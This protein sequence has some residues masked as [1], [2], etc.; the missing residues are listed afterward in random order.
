[1]ARGNTLHGCRDAYALAEAI[2]KLCE[3]AHP[4]GD[5][6]RARCPHHDGKSDTSL[7]I[8]PSDDRVLLICRAQ[9]ET[10]DIV[11]ALHLTMADLFV[12]S[13]QRPS[14]R[15]VHIYDYV[16][17]HGTLI[18][19]TVRFEP[20]SFSQRRPDPVTPGEFIWNL[21]IIEPVLYHLPHVLQAV[22]TGT[23][24]YL[25]EG[26][27]DADMLHAQGL[28]AT[29][30]PM[31]A[32]KWRTSYT[33]ALHGAHVVILTDYDNP[34]W[35]HAH[36]VAKALLGSVATLK[37]IHTFHTEEPGSDISDWIEAGGKR[38]EF[39]AIVEGAE[40]YHDTPPQTE[41]TADPFGWPARET[42][43]ATQSP[44][45]PP[46]QAGRIIEQYK[47]LLPQ[48][49]SQ[50]EE[51]LEAMPGAPLL[52][53]R[54]RRLV[55]IA[56]AEKTVQGITRASGTPIISAL[57][58]PRLRALLAQAAAWKSPNTTH[59]KVIPDMPQAWLVETLL[60][61]EAWPFPPLTGIVNSPTMRPDGSLILTQGYDEATGLWLAWDQETFPAIPP[62]PT[63]QDAQHALKMLVE[64]FQDFPFAANHHL[65]ATIAAVLTLIARYAVQSVPLFAIRATTRGSG[66]TLLADCIAMIATGRPAPKMP[67][68]KE[69]EEERK[70][71]LALA[72]DGDPL[73]VIDNVV[74]ALGNPALDLAVTSQVFKDRLLGKNAT[75]EA[76]LHTVFL[77]TGNNMT[78]KG[79]MARRALPIDLAPMLERPETRNGFVHP[80]LL[81]WLHAER[82]R[83]ISAAL[84]AL[85]AY[86]VAGKP[87]QS[88]ETYG[89]FEPWSDVIRS[90]LV[91]A[92]MDDP[93]GGRTGLE[94]ASDETF[95][96]HKELL[97]A[98]DVCYGEDTKTL[99]GI[100]GDLQFRTTGAN[101]APSTSSGTWDSLR[102]ALGFF[103]ARF[104]GQR[105][106]TKSLGKALKRLCGR[107]ID[108][109]EL[110]QLAKRAEDGMQWQVKKVEKP[111]KPSGTFNVLDV[112][113][114]NDSLSY[115]HINNVTNAHVAHEEKKKNIYEKQGETSTE[116]TAFTGMI[117]PRTD[118]PFSDNFDDL[119]DVPF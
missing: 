101:T 93:C 114:V 24:I 4:E 54:A 28:V 102:D 67:Q 55:A 5:S 105:L 56:P 31:G 87:R 61:Q 106:N 89:S 91:W 73:V 40:W 90:T 108:G 116:H 39:E 17:A 43:H 8:T 13:G 19:Q 30:N 18:H 107:V 33:E 16:D 32:K 75:K 38:E 35:E 84:T 46:A 78:F 99:A 71:I 97:A 76:P 112:F 37:I 1:M 57:T 115:A 109:K 113:S 59:T 104:D 23:P 82:P 47:H 22:A 52:F 63:R 119:S 69:E 85:R 94:A 14:R 11:H 83:L 117:L 100:V 74:G 58:A 72:L 86:W 95:E 20:K 64:P 25:V 65:T 42:P 29:C 21:K 70:R 26:E 44:A 118:D 62:T 110:K 36:H 48:V 50:A 53:Q 3:D 80:R 34:G 9:C 96:G 7:S 77:A 51:A 15:I 45:S 68:V 41:A 60:D 103:D 98:W 81:N 49:V 88:I 6:W 12:H 2:A 92:G 66:K 111:T 10:P 27:K 79:D